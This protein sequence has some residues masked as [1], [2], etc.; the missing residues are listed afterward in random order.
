MERG[1]GTT[2]PVVKY[3]EKKAVE[4][5]QWLQQQPGWIDYSGDCSI[6]AAFPLPDGN[7]LRVGLTDLDVAAKDGLWIDI[8]EGL[9]LV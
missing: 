5:I 6:Q 4:L 3:T 1:L 8:Y 2:P 7:L 9:K